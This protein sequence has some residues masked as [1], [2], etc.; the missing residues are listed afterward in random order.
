[1]KIITS[2]QFI[3]AS[4]ISSALPQ[5][6]VIRTEIPADAIIATTAGRRELSTPC[7]I[8]ILRYLR[9]SFAISMTI[10]HEGS[11]HPTV[12]TS[13]PGIPAILIPTNVAELIAIDK[14]DGTFTSKYYAV[15]RE[16]K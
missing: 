8:L 11:I 13:A 9:Y 5:N 7:S 4:E 6:A 1:M 12:D 10:I 14:T 2:V 3:P 15:R 16:L